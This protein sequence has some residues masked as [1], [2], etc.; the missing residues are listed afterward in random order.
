MNV[1]ALF[2]AL[3][4][5]ATTGTDSGYDLT[6]T[7]P[8]PDSAF[9]ITDIGSQRGSATTPPVHPSNNRTGDASPAGSQHRAAS[10]ISGTELASGA[11]G[12][13]QASGSTIGPTDATAAVEPTT[14][15][16]ATREPMGY[17]VTDVTGELAAGFRVSDLGP[18]EGATT[19]DG[20]GNSTK[21][22]TDAETELPRSGSP[23][24]PSLPTA[25]AG[26][27][28]IWVARPG[29]H[30]WDI[31][32]QTVARRGGTSTS[33]PADTARAVLRYWHRLLEANAD[34]LGD[35]PSLIY[36][37]QVIVLPD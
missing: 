18:A 31:A 20:A 13:A 7:G 14:S 34:T 23:P 17:T 4:L 15:S 35:S 26:Q 32:A 5:T 2:V 33:N 11:A 8:V 21:R 27:G 37:G 1:L 29:D 12:T 36:P 25:R 6:D 10:A 9:R 24:A 28:E 30:L 19:D 22:D 3:A 16:A